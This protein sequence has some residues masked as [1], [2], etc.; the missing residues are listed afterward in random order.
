MSVPARIMRFLVLTYQNLRAGRPSPCRFEPSCSSYALEAIE[1]HGA[2]RGA[3]LAV[4]RVARCNPFGGSGWDPVP[5]RSDSANSDLHQ[6][7]RTAA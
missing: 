3:W 2:I 5:L 1:T 6:H 7:E 4:R